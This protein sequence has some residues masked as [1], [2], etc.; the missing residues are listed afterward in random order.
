MQQIRKPDFLFAYEIANKALDAGLKATFFFSFKPE[1]FERDFLK[2]DNR[3]G[4][5]VIRPTDNCE[6]QDIKKCC[7]VF[8]SPVTNRRCIMAPPLT[9]IEMLN[10]GIPIVTTP[11]TGTDGI[12]I[13][14][15][16]GFSA[17]SSDE[18]TNRISKAI[19]GSMVM[20]DEC[21]KLV[22]DNFNIETSANRYLKLF[23]GKQ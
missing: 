15:K 3:H 2:L 20:R 13:A 6:F 17:W 7:Q 4:E 12:I 1:S 23:E 22:S 14:N 9:W 16:T 19:E 11:V 21:I 10:N 5:I 8:F 18:L